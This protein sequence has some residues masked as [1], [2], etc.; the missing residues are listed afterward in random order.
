M[1]IEIGS[2]CRDGGRPRRNRPTMAKGGLLAI[3]VLA[4]SLLC[5]E[6]WPARA[7][8]AKTDG[9]V[10]ILAEINS[11]ILDARAGYFIDIDIDIVKGDVLLTGHVREPREKMRAA[12]LVRSVPGVGSVV[13]AIR[14]GR[15]T[16]L[17][18]KSD[19]A[20]TEKR[21]SEALY[22]A[23]HKPL[24]GVAWR[25]VNGTAYVFGETSSQ[26]VHGRVF[27]IIRRVEGVGRIVDHLRIAQ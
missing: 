12:A 9:D 23:F 10:R 24:P 20:E 13:N 7:A 3:A 8:T 19:Q 6:F 2:S 11:R 22:R 14:A 18:G 26:W 16:T 4:M 27:T 1:R 21:I 15:P 5:D 17:R 25:V